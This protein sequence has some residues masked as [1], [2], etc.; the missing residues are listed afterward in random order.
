[1]KEDHGKFLDLSATIVVVARHSRE[2]IEEYWNENQIPYD[3]IADPDK[4]LGNL[5]G[6]E[7]K[8]LKLGLMPANFVIGSDGKI[9][10]AHYSSGMSDIPSNSTVLEVLEG[11]EPAD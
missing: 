7:W 6:Q 10:F 11:L 3:A 5:Y 9:A 8:A 4:K 1:M 2:E